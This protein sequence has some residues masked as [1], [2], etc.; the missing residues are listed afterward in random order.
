M[1]RLLTKKG[2]TSSTF[3]RC[4]MIVSTGYIYKV[5]VHESVIINE[6]VYLFAL[7]DMRLYWQFMQWF[8]VLFIQSVQLCFIFPVSFNLFIILLYS[9]IVNIQYSLYSAPVLPLLQCSI[10]IFI[11]ILLYIVIFILILNLFYL[12]FYIYSQYS[13][14]SAP[15]LSCIVIQQSCL[16]LS[17]VAFSFYICIFVLWC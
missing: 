1:A 13:L 17:T 10:Y 9:F 2:S 6:L 15:V 14:Y 5:K 8:S 3:F 12:Y 16:P 11:F 7:Q 4:N